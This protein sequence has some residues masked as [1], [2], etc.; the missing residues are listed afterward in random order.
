MQYTERQQC[1]KTFSLQIVR[2]DINHTCLRGSGGKTDGHQMC[3][4]IETDVEQGKA[5]GE[6][7][8]R[9]D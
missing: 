1:W 5:G 6:H 9:K 7:R 4:M 8:A 2:Q 3:R